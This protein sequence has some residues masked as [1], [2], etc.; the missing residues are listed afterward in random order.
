MRPLSKGVY[1]QPSGLVAIQDCISPPN[2]GQMFVMRKDGVIMTDESV[3]LDAPEKDTRHEKPK[4]KLM[5]CSGYANQ[6]WEYD[7]NVSTMHL[8]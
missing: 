8:S 2:L 7:E 3:C 5:A 6:K 4:V 1:S